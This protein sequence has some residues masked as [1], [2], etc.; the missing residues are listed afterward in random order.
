MRVLARRRNVSAPQARHPKRLEYGLDPFRVA[1]LARDREA[2]LEQPLRLRILTAEECQLA[3]VREAAATRRA[4]RL[5][6][7]A[8]QRF[9]RELI[10]DADEAAIEP[11]RLERI[12]EPQPGFGAVLHVAA[13]SVGRQQVLALEVEPRKP[14]SLLGADQFGARSLGEGEIEREVTRARIVAFGRFDESLVRVL[15]NGLQ[16]AVA[17]ALHVQRDERLFDEMREQVEHGTS[18]DLAPGSRPLRQ[19]PE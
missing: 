14:R 18:L 1:Q 10:S 16:Q 5:R 12:D 9:D 11:V 15:A 2:F 7:G 17:G 13:T 6:A 4:S 3:G 8:G 19:P